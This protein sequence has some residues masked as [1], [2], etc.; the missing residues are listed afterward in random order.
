M[1]TT[2]FEHETWSN[3]QIAA[4]PLVRLK[5]VDLISRGF[6]FWNRKCCVKSWKLINSA[7]KLAWHVWSKYVLVSLHY[8]TR[9]LH[10]S[11]ICRRRRF[12][13]QTWVSSENM[14]NRDVCGRTSCVSICSKWNHFCCVGM[15]SSSL[16]NL[17]SLGNQFLWPWF[18]LQ[19][20]WIWP[21]QL[22]HK[23]WRT[24][25]VRSKKAVE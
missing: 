16:R 10:L 24:N 21:V 12:S 9:W 3:I 2:I 15:V 18:F 14:E 23:N 1:K 22:Q 5:D 8:V 11:D 19:F 6:H 4:L 13:Q 25:V 7:V 17:S 20:Y